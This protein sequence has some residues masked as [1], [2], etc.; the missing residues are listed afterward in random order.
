MS[1]T[2]KVTQLEQELKLYEGFEKNMRKHSLRRKSQ[3]LQLSDDTQTF[4]N[5][6]EPDEGELHTQHAGKRGH[7]RETYSRPKKLR[8]LDSS[9][10]RAQCAISASPKN[11]AHVEVSDAEASNDD[12][13]ANKRI[14]RI[15]RPLFSLSD[16]SLQRLQDLDGRLDDT[17]I[18][19]ALKILY[20]AVGPKQVQIMDPLALDVK[21][22]QVRDMGSVKVIIPI[23]LQKYRHWVLAHVKES[24]TEVIVYDSMPSPDHQHEARGKIAQ[25]FAKFF[26]DHE[27][28]IT[29]TAPILQQNS[30]DCG[31]L[32]VAVAFHIAVGEFPPC[33]IDTVHWRRLLL[34]M[35]RPLTDEEWGIIDSAE[36]LGLLECS[37]VE[38]LTL[39][40]PIPQAS[41][42]LGYLTQESI[43]LDKIPFLQNELC[44]L[45]AEITA[46]VLGGR[47]NPRASRT[48]GERNTASLR[49]IQQLKCYAMD[50]ERSLVVQ[51]AILRLRRS[52]EYLKQIVSL[53]DSFEVSRAA[54]P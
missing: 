24:R 50:Q 11:N 43:A 28:E 52:E 36:D 39:P 16:E 10:S 23:H 38:S 1:V 5:Q 8:K 45:G 51:E 41:A 29:F 54:K 20:T 21:D 12:A 53:I 13:G 47:A 32:A 9:I 34:Q 31:V 25:W 42:V 4:P 48:M 3:Q 14:S 37:S 19:S 15:I 46:S 2:K 33:R 44:K 35:L 7:G 40:L 26:V 49:I 18:Y 22:Q 30:Y 27:P 6:N 17:S